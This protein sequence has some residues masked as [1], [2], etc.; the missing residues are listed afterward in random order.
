M[1]SKKMPLIRS[2]GMNLSVYH[3]RE[4][5]M[6]TMKPGKEYWIVTG[7]PVSGD[8]FRMILGGGDRSY[9]KFAE[10]AGR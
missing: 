9:V 8:A 6:G 5:L 7:P 4:K 3:A 2:P 1:S 10:E